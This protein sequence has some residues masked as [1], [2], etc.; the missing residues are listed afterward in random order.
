MRVTLSK[1]K[2][3]DAPIVPIAARPLSADEKEL[4]PLGKTAFLYVFFLLVKAHI[5]IT[6]LQQAWEIS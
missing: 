6:F 4:Q 3:K 1:T 2:F 5:I